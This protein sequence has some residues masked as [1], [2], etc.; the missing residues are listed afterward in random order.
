MVAGLNQIPAFAGMTRGGG[1]AMEK[2]LD[3]YIYFFVF[4]LMNVF[5]SG[6]RRFAY[7]PHE[8]LDFL[9]N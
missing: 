2:G 6:G 9:G 3:T 5:V 1:N 4:L 7:G 8:E